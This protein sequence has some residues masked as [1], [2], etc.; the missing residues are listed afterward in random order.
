MSNHE[1]KTV[2][3]QAPF[4][5]LRANGTDFSHASLKDYLPCSSWEFPGTGF[6]R[7]CGDQAG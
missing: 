6:R 4:D 1:Q 3:L 7:S 5:K 2:T